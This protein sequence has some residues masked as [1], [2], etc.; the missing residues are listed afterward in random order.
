MDNWDN[1]I[2]VR[3]IAEAVAKAIAENNRRLEDDI[4][5]M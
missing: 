1:K 5:R 3:E 2:L 4:R